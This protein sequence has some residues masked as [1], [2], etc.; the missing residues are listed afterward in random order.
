MYPRTF[1]SQ[2]L[3]HKALFGTLL[4][5]ALLISHPGN[6]RE[7]GIDP[8]EL[9]EVEL[10]GV[11]V[12][13]SAGVPLVLLRHLETGDVVP[14]IIG[15]DQARAILMAMHGVVAPRPMTHDLTI[16]M[17]T[18]L[19][20]TLE[21]VLVDDLADNTFFGMLELRVPGQEALIRVDSRPSDALALAVR[22]GATIH[23]APSVLSAGE[24]LDYEGLP[25]RQVVTA[26]GITVVEADDGE[27]SELGLPRAPGVLVRR[28]I[29]E[30]ARSTLEPGSMIL[31]VNDTAVANP[32]EFLEAIRD[33]VTG[34]K[35]RLRF[36]RDGEEGVVELDRGAGTRSRDEPMISV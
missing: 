35:V 18:A 15:I 10:A 9:V 32:M 33:T 31:E 30:A 23:V 12:S 34:D 29:G 8:A 27:R 26:L 36:W 21:R 28:V 6:A 19:G 20:A 11:G 4:V 16:S 13:T 22:S 2:P 14:I 17:L 3:A 25:D 24:D 7:L 5:A 1:A